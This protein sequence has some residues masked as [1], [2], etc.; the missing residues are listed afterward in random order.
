L[1]VKEISARDAEHLQM[2]VPYL[3]FCFMEWPVDSRKIDEA[4]EARTA[5]KRPDFLP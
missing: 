5:A 3:V 1:Y 2:I 4:G